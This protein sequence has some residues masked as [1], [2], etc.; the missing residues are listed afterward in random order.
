MGLSMARKYRWAMLGTIVALCIAGARPAAGILTDI[1]GH[2]A[3]PLV[4]AL[5][6]RGI[7]T[8]NERAQFEPDRPLTRAELAKLLV[9]GLG[10]GDDAALLSKYPSRYNDVP[11]WHWAKGYI[12]SLA[13]LG[14]VEGYPGGG[15]AP[16]EPI[17]RAQL[18]TILTRIAGGTE[19]AR[20]L[21]FEP[22]GFADDREIPAWSRGFVQV[23]HRL[24]LMQGFED[25]SFRPTQLVSRAEG[26]VA[27][28]RVL[29]YKGTTFHLT[30]TLLAFDVATGQG[31]LRTEL[32]A[33][34]TFVME[35]GAQYYRGGLPSHSGQI[36]PM[37]Q[38]WIILGQG[39]K[40]RFLDARFAD[41]LVRDLNVNGS[42]LVATTDDGTEVRLTVQRGAVVYVDGQRAQL[43]QAS[44]R[45]RAYMLLDR[46]TGEV[47][48]LDVVSSSVSG[49]YVGWDSAGR[50]IQVEAE[51]QL[52]FYP[53]RTSVQVIVNGL[54][55][56]VADLQSG[57]TLDL[58]LDSSGT[59]THVL[60]KR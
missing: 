39:G 11:A 56:A 31:V 7:V 21:R 22:T 15:F 28:F 53:Y 2:W 27:L 4:A 20:L 42:E 36:V 60:V 52:R 55:V 1:A 37:D 51:K 38:V 16:E 45:A 17:T 5:E 25:R 18:A 35:P 48:A 23:A 26:S 6:S 59:I 9:A 29:G 43:Q 33:E 32:G 50:R 49:S 58:V 8:G 44:G 30:G 54:P 10:Y 12:E 14:A 41:L 24:G 57:D 40:G 13:E 46:T 19:Q 47:R 34:R 3:G